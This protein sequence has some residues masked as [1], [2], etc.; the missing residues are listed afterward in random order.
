M[1]KR[2]SSACGPVPPPPAALTLSSLDAALDL[3]ACD[4]FTRIDALGKKFESAAGIKLQ[5]GILKARWEEAVKRYWVMKSMDDLCCGASRIVAADTVK[6]EDVMEAEG[7]AEP[8]AGPSSTFSL[9][10]C[11]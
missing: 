6:D 5:D 8:E 7:E 10:P 2:K 4:T 9:A 3:L 11:D 1:P